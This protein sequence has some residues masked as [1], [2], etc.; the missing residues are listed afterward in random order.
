VILLINRSFPL[1][2][3]PNTSLPHGSLPT[4]KLRRQNSSSASAGNRKCGTETVIQRGREHGSAARKLASIGVFFASVCFIASRT[5]DDTVAVNTLSDFSRFGCLMVEMHE[6]SDAQLLRDYAERGTEAAFGE[7]VARY[8]DLVFSAALRQVNS[9]D[10]AADL[11]QSVFTDLARKVRPL[12]SQLALDASL[13]G[14]LYRS[15]RFAALNHLRDDR[16]RAA[17]ERQAMEQL[18][19]NSESTPDWERIRPILDEA[20]AEL[21]DDDHDALLLRYFKNHDFRAVGLALGISDDA[22]Q[23]RV[24]RAVDR[25]REFFSK[26]N[27]AVGA[28]GLVILIS[29]NAVQ[30]APVGLAATISAAAVLAGTT[31]TATATATAM[32]AIAMTTLQKTVIAATL[33]VVAG[34]GIYEARQASRL[35]GEVQTLQQQ[36]APLTEQFLQLSQA[37]S[38]ATNQIAALRKDNERLNR[39]TAELL[40]LRSEVT[41]LRNESQQLA[42]GKTSDA[43]DPTA[44]AAQAWLNRVKLLKQRFDQWPGKK[45]PELQ[46]LSEQDWLNEAAKGELDSDAACREAMGHLRSTAKDRFATAVKEALEQFV[47][48]NNDQYPSDPSQLIPYLKPP[49]DSLLEGY[50]IAKPGSVHPPLPDSSEKGAETWALVEKGNFAPDGVPIRDGSNL[51][52]PEYDMYVVIYRGG[53]YMYG[54]GKPSK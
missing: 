45:T 47:K 49:S 34:T 43:N 3:R 37:F 13:V 44:I 52:D 18:L 41:G 42:Q 7:I 20:M 40:K 12:A 48:S 11:T 24:S 33:A 36:Q 39:N 28:S 2:F 17:H 54:T 5:V 38:D 26:R 31:I 27:I 23:K 53:S 1:K 32:K 35:R 4:A 21:N 51:A 15:T 8:T 10:L 30:S 19:T 25:L 50:E 16:R 9:P 46:L 6:L 22:A 14:W 29:A